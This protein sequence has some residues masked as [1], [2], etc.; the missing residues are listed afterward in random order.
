MR[1]T[2]RLTVFVR[3]NPNDTWIGCEQTWAPLIW[4]GDE[5]STED[6]I[7]DSATDYKRLQTAV[8]K[9]LRRYPPQPGK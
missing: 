8:V 9:L 4:R 7:R 2:N 1:L 3:T 6:L 5:T